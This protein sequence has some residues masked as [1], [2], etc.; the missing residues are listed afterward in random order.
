VPEAPGSEARGAA[1][2]EP[3]RHRPADTAGPEA[4]ETTNGSTANRGATGQGEGS[5]FS[6]RSKAMAVILED[7][8]KYIRVEADA[9]QGV[10]YAV[11]KEYESREAREL[12]KQYGPFKNHL[13]GMAADRLEV[14]YGDMYETAEA[15]G[16]DETVVTSDEAT[17]GFCT[18]HPDFAVKYHRYHALLQEEH[19]LQLYCTLAGH[20]LPSL[21]MLSA[22]AIDDQAFSVACDEDFYRTLAGATPPGDGDAD[23]AAPAS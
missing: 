14:L 10:L 16:F 6:T 12:E 9:A 22:M 3:A 5:G 21:P 17:A 8:N 4:G 18:L 2:A 23:L 20:P 15:I 7:G 13:L 11:I 1:A 19:D